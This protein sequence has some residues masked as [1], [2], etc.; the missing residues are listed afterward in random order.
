MQQTRSL[1]LRRQQAAKPMRRCIACRVSKPQD[2][3]MRFTF[4]G[5]KVIADTGAPRDGRGFYL[6]G[7]DECIELAVKRRAFNRACKQNIDTEEIRT[8]IGQALDNFQG[9]TDAKES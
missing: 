1:K 8:V 9:G 6:C 7:N 5:S 2:E 3:L 4:D